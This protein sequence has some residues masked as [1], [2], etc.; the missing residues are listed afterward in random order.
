MTFL[1]FE[2]EL[3]ELRAIQSNPSFDSSFNSIQLNSLFPVT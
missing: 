1:T 2:H 3:N